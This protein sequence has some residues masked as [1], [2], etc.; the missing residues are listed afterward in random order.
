MSFMSATIVAIEEL[1]ARKHPEIRELIF[2]N[3]MSGFEKQ[4]LDVIKLYQDE[5]FIKFCKDRL[6]MDLHKYVESIL[7]DKK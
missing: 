1:I 6:D 7:K 4:D 5:S 2:V 3:I